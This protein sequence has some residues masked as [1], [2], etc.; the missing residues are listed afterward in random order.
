VRSA[1][2]ADWRRTPALQAGLSLELPAVFLF[3]P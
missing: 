3:G 2:V 1:R